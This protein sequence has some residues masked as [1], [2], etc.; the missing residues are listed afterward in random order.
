MKSYKKLTEEI[1]YQISAYLKA[2]FTQTE[3]SLSVGVHKSTIS[4]EIRRNS[5]LR[6][7][8]P[9]QVQIKSLDRRQLKSQSRID[10]STWIRVERMLCED[11]SLEQVS[12][13]LVDSGLAS[14]SPE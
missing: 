2:G 9:R 3:I 5:G 7:Y 8:R 6:G 4:R 11:W 14:V 10:Q 12:K 1:R 13:R